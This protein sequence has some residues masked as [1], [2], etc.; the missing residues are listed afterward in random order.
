MEG[1]EGKTLLLMGGYTD[2]LLNIKCVQGPV[3]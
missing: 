3:A 1:I 2:K